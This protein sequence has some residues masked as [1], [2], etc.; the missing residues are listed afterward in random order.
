MLE[1]ILVGIIDASLLRKAMQSC[2]GVD[3]HRL[4][5]FWGA[6]AF[7]GGGIIR[8]F[9]HH[10]ARPGLAFRRLRLPASR[11]KAA[12][13]FSERRGILGHVSLVSVRVRNIDERNPVALCHDIRTR[14]FPL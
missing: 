6:V 10:H 12:A 11:Q 9:N 1:G 7:Q 3:I 5:V 14:C 13:E 4:C 2:S 8:E